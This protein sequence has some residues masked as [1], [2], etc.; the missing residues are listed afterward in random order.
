MSCCWKRARRDLLSLLTR[1]MQRTTLTLYH[2]GWI[3]LLCLAM[4]IMQSSGGIGVELESGVRRVHFRFFRKDLRKPG[5]TTS[6]SF[7]PQ[8]TTWSRSYGF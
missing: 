3:A 6:H 8:L 7:T 2:A 4:V 1:N 5:Y